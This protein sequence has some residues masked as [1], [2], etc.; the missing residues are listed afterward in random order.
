MNNCEL[1]KAVV[2]KSQ[3]GQLLWNVSKNNIDTEKMV[4][5]IETVGGTII[6]ITSIKRAKLLI[7]SDTKNYPVLYKRYDF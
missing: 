4:I 7:K 5:S 1:E 6:D 3:D 2:F